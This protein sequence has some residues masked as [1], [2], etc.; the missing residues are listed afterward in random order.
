[1]MTYKILFRALITVGTIVVF[2]LASCSNNVDRE[3]GPSS[4]HGTGALPGRS[5]ITSAPTGF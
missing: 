5:I 3:F 1:M 2:A 4:L